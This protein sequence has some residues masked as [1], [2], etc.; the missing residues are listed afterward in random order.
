MPWKVAIELNRVMKTGALGFIVAPGAW[1]AHEEPWDYW[2]Y[3]AHS[4]AALFNRA[5]GFEIIE[6]QQGEQ[7]TLVSQRVHAAVNFASSS[8]CHLVSAVLFRKIGTTSLDW[9]VSLSD[10]VQTRYPT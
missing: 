3:S 9:P 5:T 7:A 1:P 2:R 10:V 4:F 8:V 6:T